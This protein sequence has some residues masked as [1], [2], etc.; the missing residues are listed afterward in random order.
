MPPRW[1]S[2]AI[3]TFWLGTSGWLLWHDLWPQW[4]PGEP[5]PY[6]IDLIEE[7]TG[8][9]NKPR[10]IAWTVLHNDE[11]VF[12]AETWVNHPAPDVFELKAEYKP[13]Q[14]SGSDGASMGLL[15]V[16]RI[17]S[18]LRVT[19]T[20][21]LLGIEFQVEGRFEGRLDEA[22]FDF[23]GKLT[24]QVRGTRLSR[25]LQ[26]HGPARFLDKPLDLGPVEV[27]AHGSALLPWHPVNRIQGLRP[28]RRWRQPVVDPIADSLAVL[29]SLSP[30]P[31]FLDALVRPGPEPLSYK[32]RRVGCLVIDYQGEEG[33]EASTWV[34]ED[35]GLVLRQEVR[36]EGGH[37]EMR[38]EE[39][40]TSSRPRRSV[41]P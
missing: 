25:S 39:P 35:S 22:T 1:L 11:P 14:G 29:N 24:G 3:V 32:G 30:A 12:R 41:E 19:E 37:W 33:K 17:D 7:V 16:R 18:T 40:A 9:N 15:R 36:A 4:R 6:V 34:E 28:G 5:P 27:P 20:G 26:V 23:E 10:T 38:R 13:P 2:L 8:S 21:R 31:R